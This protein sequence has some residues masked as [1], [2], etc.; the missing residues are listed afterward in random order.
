MHCF[1][2]IATS[3]RRTTTSVLAHCA[4]AYEVD[5]M[6]CEDHSDR[7]TDSTMDRFLVKRV[8]DKKSS[9]H[10]T[11]YLV[12]V[13]AVA[14]VRCSAAVIAA[15]VGVRAGRADDDHRCFLLLWRAHFAH[16]TRWSARCVCAHALS[17]TVGR[18]EQQRELDALVGAAGC[19]QAAC[20]ALF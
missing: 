11:S 12:Q 13:C 19:V 20:C 1:A 6:R 9:R 7:L 3:Q 15:R 8:V 18:S 17:H 2:D 10:K 4:M 14:C 16:G 5:A